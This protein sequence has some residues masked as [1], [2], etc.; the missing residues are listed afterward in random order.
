MTPPPGGTVVLVLVHEGHTGTH[1]LCEALSRLSCVYADCSEPDYSE[2]DLASFVSR[3]N[4]TPYA[5]R[6][7]Q[8]FGPKGVVSDMPRGLRAW[9]DRRRIFFLQHTRLDLL[10]WSLSHYCKR[11]GGCSWERNDP[12]FN[13]SWAD[14]QP[15]YYNI[16]Q[17]RRAAGSC[18]ETWNYQINALPDWGSTGRSTLPAGRSHVLFYEDLL[19]AQQVVQGSDRLE[20]YVRWVLAQAKG[21]ASP[22]SCGVG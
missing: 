8:R 6:M 7:Y 2:A 9:V 18:L 16:S 13:T 4:E 14:H 20:S 19:A 22:A 17:L 11:G 15:H 3:A 21:G 12:Q 5:V 10:R 1:A